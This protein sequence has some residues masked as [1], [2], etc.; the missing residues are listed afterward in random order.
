MKQF[1]LDTMTAMM[2]AMFPMFWIGVI[3]AV[4]AIVLYIVAAKTGYK[5]PLWAARGGMA[6][7]LFFVACQVAGFLLGAGP[8]LNFG[9]PKN[10]EFILVPFWVLGLG[11][12]I[13]SWIVWSFASNKIMK[14]AAD[15]A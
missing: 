7:G 1:M 12:L 14:G 2:P 15:S 6:F 5:A 9:D 10:F 8:S 13:P 4:L 11:L 3:L